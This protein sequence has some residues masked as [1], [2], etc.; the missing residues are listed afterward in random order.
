MVILFGVR[1]VARGKAEPELEG[2][3]EIA[4][5]KFEWQSA[6]ALLR[7][8]TLIPLFLQGFF[9]VFPLNVMTFSFFA[10]L[11]RDRGYDNTLILSIMGAAVLLMALGAFVGGALGDRLF[12]VNPRGRLIVSTIGVLMGTLFLYLALTTPNESISLF[13]V[14][15]GATAFFTLFSGPNVAA[16]LYD[17]TL[18]EVRSSALAL[19]YFL[20]SFG[21]AFAPLIVGSI[22][23]QAGQTLG[24]AIAAVAL[25]TWLICGLF[26]VAAVYFV[27]RDIRLLREQ[28]AAR[29]AEA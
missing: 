3:S 14:L 8:R 23:V 16:T 21:A 13:A 22:A 26:L 20:E 5:H 4:I 9:G 12:R 1:D 17:I 27:P 6:V 7:K 24:S 29:A 25:T 10:Y 15:L 18:P 19:Q 28:M 11:E 2:M